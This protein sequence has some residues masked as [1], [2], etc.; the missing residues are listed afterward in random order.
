MTLIKK[1]SK[2]FIC[3]F[4]FILLKNE[5]VFAYQEIIRKKCGDYTYHIQILV[6]ENENSYIY[7]QK[8]YLYS[9]SK[10]YPKTLFYTSDDNLFGLQGGCIKGKHGKDLFLFQI[11]TGGN[12][13]PEDIIGVFD[14]S[15][16]KI[17]VTPNFEKGNSKQI[18]AINKNLTPYDL[19]SDLIFCCINY[20][21]IPRLH[22][23]QLKYSKDSTLAR[24]FLNANSTT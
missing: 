14:P 5:C 21:D 9:S 11:Y 16:K 19:S 15:R 2:L 7:N 23:G 20:L 10:K 6:N 17:I 13:T 8:Y 3:F 24:L 4:V 1:F 12:H 18:R 22:R